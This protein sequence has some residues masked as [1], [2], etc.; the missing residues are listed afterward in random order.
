M[1][2]RPGSTVLG[3]GFLRPLT[4][5]GNSAAT[6]TRTQSSATLNE[7]IS[8]GSTSIV[9][10]GVG[11]AVGMG[12]SKSPS[13]VLSQGY[14]APAMVRRS[15]EGDPRELPVLEQRRRELRG[16]EAEGDTSFRAHGW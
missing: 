3:G 9:G 4:R 16:R 2:R 1:P 14:E 8:P 12:H 10:V 5:V 11:A 6:I 15:T 7:H 13:P